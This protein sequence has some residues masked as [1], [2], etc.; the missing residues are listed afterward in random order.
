MPNATTHPPGADRADV[1]IVGFDVEPDDEGA[2]HGPIFA[3]LALVLSAA[4]TASVAQSRGQETL[5]ADPGP[6]R[7]RSCTHDR[8][9]DGKACSSCAEVGASSF[10]LDSNYR[11]HNSDRRIRIGQ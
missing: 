7:L 5:S 9:A 6:P 2:L 4:A 11:S 1:G 3:L 8:E 10:C